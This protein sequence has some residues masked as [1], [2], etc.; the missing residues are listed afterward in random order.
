MLFGDSPAQGFRRG[1]DFIHPE[2][3][4]AFTVPPG[5]VL[6]N[7]AQQVVALGPNGALVVFDMERREEIARQVPNMPT[8]L[9]RVWAS[10]VEMAGIEELTIDGAEAATGIT[11]LQTRSGAVVA[12]LVAI[13]GGPDRVWRFAFL[14]SPGDAQRLEGEF[15]RTAMSFR[16]L[17]AQQAAAVKPWRVG[18]VTVQA[19]DTPERLAERM[20][21]DTYRLETFRALN[22]LDAG[23]RLT[24]GQQVKIVVG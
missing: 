15:Q 20:V 3:R 23:A 9:T 6:K 12:R 18:V 24:P 11:R 13:R 7:N 2:L 1:R 22:A 8:Y 10:N 16:R 14:A 5:F 21:M 17:S 4:I 19:G